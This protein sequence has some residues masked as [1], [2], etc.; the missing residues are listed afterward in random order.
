MFEDILVS[1]HAVTPFNLYVCTHIGSIGHDIARAER[2]RLA[3][4]KCNKEKK[5]KMPTYIRPSRRG[6]ADAITPDETSPEDL[7]E[8]WGVRV[9]QAAMPSRL[10]LIISNIFELE[11]HVIGIPVSFVSRTNLE[12]SNKGRLVFL[13]FP[14]QS[15]DIEQR[16]TRFP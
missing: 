8:R 9:A 5:F 2:Q 15:G 3:Y 4:L 14:H 7:N 1:S 13:G 16:A 10:R 6:A 12:I 11:R